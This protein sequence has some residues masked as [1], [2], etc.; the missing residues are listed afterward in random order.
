MNL[1]D[2]FNVM[3][4]FRTSK[5]QRC[6]YF[7]SLTLPTILPPDGWTEQEE[8]PQPFSS[9]AARGVT[10][11]ASRML[12]ALLP[13]NDLP[14]FKFELG[15]GEEPEPDIYS[16]LDA[17]SYQVFNKLSSANLREIIYQALQHLIIVGDVL[18]IMDDDFNFRLQRLDQYVSKRDVHGVLEELIYIEFQ[19]IETETED[20]IAS[21]TSQSSLDH[22][23]YKK[24]YVRAHKSDD[25]WLVEKQDADGNVIEKGEYASQPP[26]IAL[27]WSAI[28]GENYGRSHIED[29]IGDIKALEAFTEGLIYGVTAA[30]LF[31]M[32]IDPAGMTELDDVASSPTGSW[33]SA[34]AGEVFTISPADTMNPQIQSTQA[35]VSILREEVGKAFLMG[36][37]SIPQGERVTATAV[38]MIGQ[39]LEHVLGGA[40]SAIARDLMKP[41]VERSIFLMISSGDIDERLKEMFNEQGLLDVEIVTG[42]Q[43]LSRDTDL[44]KLMQMGEMVR[45]LPEQAM[46]MFKWDQYGAALITALG[47]APDS[48]I[49]SEEE[50]QQEQQAIQ[51]QQMAMQ[52]QQQAQTGMTDAIT[53]G[54]AQMAQQDIEQTGG[55]GIQQMMQGAM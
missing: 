17:L 27:R 20:L 8:L 46:A 25:K 12:S 35:G 3:D 15:S 1:P 21:Y 24:I 36:G 14:F 31:W 43:A 9:Q 29:M 53:Q 51:E 5:L 37:S 50:V 18:L 28:P 38:R 40:F 45:N 41:I 48:W 30:S 33:V 52:A 23:G 39:E 55:Q 22:K 6:R 47:F 54:A 16:Y 11:M 4:S 26:F 34:R 42:L 19:S 2:R 13:L 49:K 32:G 10:S 44:Q 7:S